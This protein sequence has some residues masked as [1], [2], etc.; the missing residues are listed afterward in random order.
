MVS[1]VAG[2]NSTSLPLAVQMTAQLTGI[3]NYAVYG[4][5]QRRNERC[6]SPPPLGRQRGAAVLTALLLVAAAIT[7]V[8]PNSV[9]VSVWRLLELPSSLDLA[10]LRLMARG[11]ERWAGAVLVR[12]GRNSHCSTIPEKAGTARSTIYRWKVEPPA[13]RSLTSKGVLTSTTFSSMGG[14]TRF[15]WNALGASS[16]IFN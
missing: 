9:W 12:D 3:E 10:Q 16:S 14:L 7:A 6:W 1:P 13:D 8:V 15:G 5:W 4:R 2:G 11:V